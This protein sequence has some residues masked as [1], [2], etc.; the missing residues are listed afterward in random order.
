MILL[1]LHEKVDYFH[2]L[3][4]VD[5]SK[6]FCCIGCNAEYCRKLMEVGSRPNVSPTFILVPFYRTLCGHDPVQNS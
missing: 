3:V 4:R 6:D 5:V 2:V 1:N